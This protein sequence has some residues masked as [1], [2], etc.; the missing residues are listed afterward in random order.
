M[1]RC[2]AKFM[3]ASLRL[4]IYTSVKSRSG[5]ASF[6]S[7]FFCSLALCSSCPDRLLSWYG[8]L[9]LSRSDWFR[10]V[11]L[12]IAYKLLKCPFLHSVNPPAAL[13]C[14]FAYVLIFLFVLESFNVLQNIKIFF[15][16]FAFL[17]SAVNHVIKEAKFTI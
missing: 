5:F 17:L 8:W 4:Y 14:S 9:S 10:V 15:S 6:D 12:L 3:T 7:F 2:M 11:L 13:F 1:R 16:I